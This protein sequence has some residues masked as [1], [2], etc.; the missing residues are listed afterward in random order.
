MCSS[1]AAQRAS[2]SST[3]DEDIDLTKGG[4]DR[5]CLALAIVLQTITGLDALD[6][7]SLAFIFR[8]RIDPSIGKRICFYTNCH[9]SFAMP[10][11][12]GL[13]K[14]KELEVAV[15]ENLDWNRHCVQGLQDSYS[16]AEDLPFSR[17]L[18]HDTA[19]QRPYKSRKG[20]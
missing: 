13:E 9:D 1:L 8:C 20:E 17:V 4:E 18:D 10:L 15:K 2:S 3:Q 14:V 12:T 11:K 6:D 5:R 16:I 7:V 19:E